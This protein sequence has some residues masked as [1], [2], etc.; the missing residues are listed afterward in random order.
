MTYIIVAAAAIIV[1][2]WAYKKGYLDFAKKWFSKDETT[3]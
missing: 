1:F 3:K 2:V